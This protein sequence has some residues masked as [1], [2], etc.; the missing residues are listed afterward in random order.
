MQLSNVR[1][2][3]CDL[4]HTWASWHVQNGTPTVRL[5]GN[6][7]MVVCGDSETLCASRR[8]SLGPF[9][10]ASVRDACRANGNSRHIY[11][12]TRKMKGLAHLQALEFLVVGACYPT[13]LRG[14]K[15]R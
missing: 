6:G 1:V 15:R 9:C 14:M 10:R 8:G 3:W 4:R 2:R 7:W 5:A 13:R 12:T 11:G